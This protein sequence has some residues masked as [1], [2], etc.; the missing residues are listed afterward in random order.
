MDIGYGC[1]Q[2]NCFDNLDSFSYTY[3]SDDC[4]TEKEEK[5]E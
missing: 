1:K 5:E 3:K 4:M 2:H